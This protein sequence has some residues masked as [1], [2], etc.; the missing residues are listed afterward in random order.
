[1]ANE[2]LLPQHISIYGVYTSTFVLFASIISFIYKYYVLHVL[3]F[4][5]YITSILHWYKLQDGIIRK[6]D[7]VFA[8]MTILDI[9]FVDSYY[10]ISV[11]RTLWIIV[12]FIGLI[13]Y[14]CN[15]IA[16]TYIIPLQPPFYI[17]I[18][19]IHKWTT[20]THIFMFHICATITCSYCI[21]SSNEY[22]NETIY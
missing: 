8:L 5:L 3:T 16:L 19:T 4:C 12:I 21:I 1:M 15:E 22:K 17:R 7:K 13:T 9:T 10:F 2:L 11:Y 18:E 6:L 14:C 20:I